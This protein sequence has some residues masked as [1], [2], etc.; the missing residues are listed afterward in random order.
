MKPLLVPVDFS[1]VSRHV[2]AEAT[3]LARMMKCPITLI[4]VVEP[5]PIIVSD[6]GAVV[7][8]TVQITAAAEKSAAQHLA[9][10]RS[11][12]KKAGLEVAAV[13]RTGFPVFHI[14]ELA[15]KLRASHIVIGSHGHTAFYDLL[16]GSTTGGVL[17]RAPCPVVIVPMEARGKDRATQKK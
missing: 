12:L 15:K 6:F 8:S 2:M 7:D 4:H 9:K 1:D 3:K 11:K 16:I 17:K 13:L 5:P 14:A 10:L